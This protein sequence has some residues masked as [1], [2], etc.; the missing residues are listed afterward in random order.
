MI[1]LQQEGSFDWKCVVRFTGKVGVTRWL[2]VVPDQSEQ[3]GR[4]P[5]ELM[6]K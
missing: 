5:A 3:S 1:V 6:I 4:G 2:E